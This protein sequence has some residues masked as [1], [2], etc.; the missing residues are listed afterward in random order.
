[1]VKRKI[2]QHNKSHIRKPIAN[3]ILHSEMLKALSL[4]SG[5][6]QECPFQPCIFNIVLKGIDRA[7]K[8]EKETKAKSEREN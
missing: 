6:R 3:I 5:T 2:C 1:M 4:K 7:I 8:Q